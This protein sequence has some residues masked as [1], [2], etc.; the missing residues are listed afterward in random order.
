MSDVVCIMDVW[1][2]VCGCV[3]CGMGLCRCVLCGAAVGRGV[4]L[5]VGPEDRFVIQIVSVY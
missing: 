5:K 3:L 2:C 4:G 1:A